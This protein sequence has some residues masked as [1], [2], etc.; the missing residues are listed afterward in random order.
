MTKLRNVMAGITN[1]TVDGSTH[2]TARMSVFTAGITS[3][4]DTSQYGLSSTLSSPTP[5]T[6]PGQKEKHDHAGNTLGKCRK[7]CGLCVR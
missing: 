2:L 1:I 6:E 5:S 3:S 7:V 4:M